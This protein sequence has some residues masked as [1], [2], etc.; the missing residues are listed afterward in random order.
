MINF[1]LSLVFLFTPAG[2]KWYASLDEFDNKYYDLYEK[3]PLEG[4]LINYVKQYLEDF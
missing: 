1:L 4:I 3:E 2:E